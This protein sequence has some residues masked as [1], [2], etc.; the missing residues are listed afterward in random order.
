MPTCD[1]CSAPVSIYN[2]HHVR[3]Y[4][5]VTKYG[6]PVEIMS[7]R[8]TARAL[9]VRGHKKGC[10]CMARRRRVGRRFVIDVICPD[11]G[12]ERELRTDGVH[13]HLCWSDYYRRC[14]SCSSRRVLKE[15]Q[16]REAA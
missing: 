6:E 3:C 15:R 1:K 4:V 12:G 13:T 16:E 7:V 14:R 8:A 9:N 5:C 2:P 10:L 11:C